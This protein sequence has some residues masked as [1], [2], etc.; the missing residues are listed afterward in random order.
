[1][2][3]KGCCNAELQEIMPKN[4]VPFEQLQDIIFKAKNQYAIEGVTLL[5]GEPTLQKGLAELCKYIHSIDLTVILFTGKLY[6]N[7][8]KNILSHIDLLVDGKFEIDKLDDKRNMVG[9]TNQRI[10]CT[11]DKY[12]DKLDWFTSRR[13]KQVELNFNNNNL[14]I[15][16]DVL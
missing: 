1:M 16:G 8:S 15:N 13:I 2:K 10:I 6:E 9:S 5:G 3:C 7:L 4:I 11:S 12:K 14:F